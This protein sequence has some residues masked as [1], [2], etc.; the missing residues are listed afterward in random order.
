MITAIEPKVS[1]TGKYSV[2]QTCELLGIHRN[3]LRKYTLSGT[4]RCKFHKKNF[5][6]FY[7]GQEIIKFWR[8]F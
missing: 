3:T 7:T 2:S 1:D 4:I 8:T 6:K 5:R